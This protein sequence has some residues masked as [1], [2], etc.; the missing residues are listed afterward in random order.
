MN[1]LKSLPLLSVIRFFCFNSVFTVLRA[2]AS[3]DISSGPVQ[4]MGVCF[5]TLK[6]EQNLGRV[7]GIDFTIILIRGLPVAI[8]IVNQ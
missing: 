8:N 7:P 3:L 6:H 2:A 4:N 1:H 5:G